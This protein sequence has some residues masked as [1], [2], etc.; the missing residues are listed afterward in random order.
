MN[1]EP[2]VGKTY[3]REK[4]KEENIRYWQVAIVNRNGAYDTVNNIELQNSF[5]TKR[6]DF[7]S[8]NSIESDA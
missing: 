4:K 7:K 2:D 6:V 8:Y 5:Q 3:P 1:R